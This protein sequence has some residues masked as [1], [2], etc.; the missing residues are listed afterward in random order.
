ML[1]ISDIAIRVAVRT[2]LTHSRTDMSRLNIGVFRGVVRLQG[3]L[4]RRSVQSRFS[5]E[6]VIGIEEALK[7]LRGVERVHWELSNWTK[8]ES[9]EWRL[10][11]KRLRAKRTLAVNKVDEE[12]SPD[13][14]ELLG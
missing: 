11:E 13:V 8:Q 10:R 1:R 2:V 3:E 14:I 12:L 7:G 6:A 4:R 5:V 9:G